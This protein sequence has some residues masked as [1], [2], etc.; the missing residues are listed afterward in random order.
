LNIMGV[1]LSGIDICGMSSENRTSPELCARWYQVATFYPFA[2]NHNIEGAPS[3]EPYVWESV[4]TITRK[5]LAARYSLLP[6]YNTLFAQAHRHGRTVVRPLFFEFAHDIATWRIDT[7]FLIGSGLLI[8]PV[9]TQGATSRDIYLPSEAKWYDFWTQHSVNHTGHINV[10]APIDHMPI[11]LRGGVIYPLQS[12]GM[13]TREQQYNPYQL[14]VC[15]DYHGAAKGSLF[16]DDG[17]EIN[18]GKRAHIIQYQ[19][20]QKHLTAQIQQHTYQPSG[21]LYI[22]TVRILGVA[23]AVSEV[24]YNHHVMK[25]WS[26]DH[27]THCLFIHSIHLDIDQPFTITWN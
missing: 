2:R 22:D 12:P 15:L 8:S 3:Q 9:L 7:Q 1:P 17:E 13:N 5:C 4:A 10:Q 24:K 25:A 27:D 11:H 16:V 23:S 20:Q 21:P 6:Y 18:V 26:Y 14:Y 19:A